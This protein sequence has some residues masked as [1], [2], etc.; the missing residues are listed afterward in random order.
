M[1]LLD[2]VQTTAKSQPPRLVL[3]AAEKFGKTSFGAFT[4]KPIVLMTAGETGLIPLIDT[5]RIPPVPHFP[6]DFRGWGDL[7]RSVQALCDEPHDYKTLVLDTGNGAEQLCAADICREHF[8]GRWSDYVSYGRGDALAAKEWARFLA[9]LDE[10]QA[11]RSMAVLMLQ[12]AK[13][14]TFVDPAGKDFDQW[15]PEGIEKCWQLTHKWADAILFGGFR[16]RVD[17]DGKATG[18]ER[19]IQCEATGGIVAGNRYGLPA[20]ITAG[21]GAEGLWKAFAR[22]YADAKGRGRPA[23]VPPPPPPALPVSASPA[24][25]SPHHPKGDAPASDDHEEHASAI[26]ELE[27][28]CQSIKTHP[29][30][31]FR[32]NCVQLGFHAMEPLPPWQSLSLQRLRDLIAKAEQQ[33]RAAENRRP[34]VA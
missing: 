8:S 19:Y 10:L 15:K 23:P 17:R 34:V 5:G 30:D 32:R 13:T 4:W 18:W 6:D 16:T 14:K 24:A 1:G 28:L 3:Y 31:L 7:C 12:H 22:A 9:L 27:Q 20:Q 25:T 2:R 11:V 33:A 29:L 26:Y 21:D